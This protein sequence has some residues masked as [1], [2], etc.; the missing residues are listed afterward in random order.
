MIEFSIINNNLGRNMKV[1]KLIGAG[2]LAVSLS[3]PVS[4]SA[5]G[6]SGS[7]LRMVYG[8]G[9]G[10]SK[11]EAEFAAIRNLWET[12]GV[13]R[14]PAIKSCSSITHKYGVHWTCISYGGTP[15]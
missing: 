3:A 8:S 4:V 14:F 11:Q 2:L 15:V 12:Y 1:M 10:P 13:I 5:A 9:G 6:E 7:G